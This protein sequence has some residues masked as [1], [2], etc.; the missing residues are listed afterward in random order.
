MATAYRNRTKLT[1]AGRVFLVFGIVAIFPAWNTGNNLLYLLAAGFYSILLTSWMAARMSPRTIRLLRETPQAVHRNEPFAATIRVESLRKI[2]PLYSI[3]IEYTGT[4]SVPRAYILS[5]PARSDATVRITDTFQKRGV[6][7][8][9]PVRLTTAFPFGLIEAAITFVDDREIVV[10]PRITPLRAVG[11]DSA[12]GA[13]DAPRLTKADGNEYFSLRDYVPGD[14]LRR[15]AWR[16]SARMGN[17]IV[18]ELEHETVRFVTIV[19]DARFDPKSMAPE[20]HENDPDDD[21]FE[22]AVEMAASLA[23]SLLQRQYTVAV[24]ANDR[25]LNEGEGQSHVLKVL[26]FFARI[27]PL[28]LNAPDVYGRIRQIDNPYTTYLCISPDPDAWGTHVSV[29]K[30]VHPAEVLRA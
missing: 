11:L 21:T 24:L 7:Q 22:Q 28:Q 26:D 13:G 17:L 2:L 10:Y 29:G 25:S 8:L 15:I 4:Q 5:L 23:V 3:S 30:I 19:F 12:A 6:H 14:D 27:E 9:A 1:K 20:R 16:V 18:R